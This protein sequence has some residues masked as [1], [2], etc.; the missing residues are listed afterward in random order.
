MLK[1]DFLIFKFVHQRRFIFD[2][3]TTENEKLWYIPLTWLK[4]GSDWSSP[5][6]TW[7]K[8]SDEETLLDDVGDSNDYSWVIFNVNSIGKYKN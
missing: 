1:Y 6:F 2:N 5:S 4:S 8:P 7:I 3:L